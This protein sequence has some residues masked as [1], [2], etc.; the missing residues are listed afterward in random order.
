[1]LYILRYSKN[2]MGFYSMPNL[3][4]ESGGLQKYLKCK[5]LLIYAVKMCDG[6]PPPGD[7]HRMIQHTWENT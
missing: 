3:E 4:V 5:R 1:M 6:M 7:M 2:M